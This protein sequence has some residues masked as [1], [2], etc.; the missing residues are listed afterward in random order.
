MI[1]I[2]PNNECKAHLDIKREMFGKTV[3]CP[4]CQKTI[5]LKT[6]KTKAR[7]SKPVVNEDL[8]RRKEIA[9]FKSLLDGKTV[10]VNSLLN[11]SPKLAF[12]KDANGRLPAHLVALKGYVEIMEI[13]LSKGADIECYDK[14]K[15]TP[16]HYAAE[17]GSMQMVEFLLAKGAKLTPQDI[18]HKTPKDLANMNGHGDIIEILKENLN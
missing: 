9:F 15:R 5:A 4:Q 1:I 18:K 7:T 13:L 10:A 16:L 2:C 14:E 6:Y 11:F 3:R 17:A 12:T 8:K